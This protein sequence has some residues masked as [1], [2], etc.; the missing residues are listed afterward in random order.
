MANGLDA[1]GTL[2]LFAE[3]VHAGRVTLAGVSGLVNV[4]IDHG[5]RYPAKV[6]TA[7]FAAWATAEKLVQS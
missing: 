2:W 4:L 6:R 3:A 1:H 5:A 7:G